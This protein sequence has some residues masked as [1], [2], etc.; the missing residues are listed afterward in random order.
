MIEKGPWMYKPDMETRISR[1]EDK[2]DTLDNKMK[3]S[4]EQESTVHFEIAVLRKEMKE[5][6]I[7]VDRRFDR[8]E[9]EITGIKGEITGIKGEITGIKGEITG[10]KELLFKIAEKVGV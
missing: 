8:I 1:V 2:V 3:R 10:I 9:G 5:G 7:G 4:E 6:F